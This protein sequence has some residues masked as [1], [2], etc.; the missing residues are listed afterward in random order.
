MRIAPLI[1][2][3]VILAVV[4]GCGKG[5]QMDYGHPTAQFLGSSVA[6]K[7]KEYVGK[8]ITVKG[9]VAK[10]DATDPE[11]VWIQLDDGVR[12]NLGKFKSMAESCKVGDTVYVDGVLKHCESSVV[13][14]EP[15]ILR[16]PTTS[17]SPVQ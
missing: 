11:S 2:A 8:K 13:L 4:D 7:G 14:L 10:V 1:S 3:L 15:A 6:T 12:C 9:T 17:F 16:D 5:L